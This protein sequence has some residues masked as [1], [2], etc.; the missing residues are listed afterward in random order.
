VVVRI[1]QD[2]GRAIPAMAFRACADRARRDLLDDLGV[3]A[4]SIQLCIDERI[5]AQEFRMDLEGI[6]VSEG[7]IPP[8]SLLVDDDPV[9]LELLAVPFETT[10]PMATRARTIWVASDHQGLLDK[11]GVK[12]TTPLEALAEGLAA[13]LRR[14]AT[15]FV[16]IQETRRLIA[17]IEPD[18]GD[19]VK[20]LQKSTPLPKIAEILRR[21]VQEEVPI[22]N[23]RLILE[24]L[25]EWGQREQDIVLLVEY[26]RVALRREIC[27]RVADPNRVIAAYLID[28]AVEE[29]IRGALRKT[30]VGTF[31]TLPETA[32]QPII[33][34]LKAML[35]GLDGKAR[36]VVLTA[37]DIR[38]HVRNLL[39]NNDITIPV[40]S[41]QEIAPEFNALPLATVAPQ[42]AA[43][44]GER[45]VAGAGAK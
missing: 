5:G 32:A 29:Q 3:E 20:E 7:A 15:Q 43:A 26:V 44:A 34:R 9:H 36:P 41:F 22:R 33:A 39:A 12:T 38:R 8:D 21:L 16:G 42:A 23:L 25:I 13:T 27:F 6:P 19:L 35:D 31:L 30:A 28:R 10:P 17:R 4:R 24:A 37:M 40:L 1:G 45:I 2:L 18:Y 14:H 11:A